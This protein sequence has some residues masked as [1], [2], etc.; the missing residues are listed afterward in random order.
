V[1]ISFASDAFDDYV[2]WQSEDRTVLLRLNDLIKQ[3]ARTPFAGTGKPEP[4]KDQF[5]GWWSRRITQEHRL[6]YR[7]T[8][9]GADQTLEIVACR[10]HYS[11]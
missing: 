2:F 7:M 5:R 6:V 4:L 9:K 8:G 10:F 11:K 3:C 1:K